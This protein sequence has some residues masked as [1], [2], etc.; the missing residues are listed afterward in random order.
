[1]DMVLPS[2]VVDVPGGDMR[3][4]A[5]L[6]LNVGKRQEPVGMFTFSKGTYMMAVTVELKRLRLLVIVIFFPVIEFRVR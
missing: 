6:I 5:V 1:M 2:S 4:R 3:M